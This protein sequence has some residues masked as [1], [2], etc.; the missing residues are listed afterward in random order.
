MNAMKPEE[1]MEIEVVNLREEFV[2]ELARLDA[3]SF[4]DPWSER[5]YRELLTHSYSHYLVALMAEKPIGFAGM[6]VSFDE[7]DIDRV[8]VAP[9]LRRKGVADLLMEALFRLGDEI[10]VREYTLE[11]RRSNITAIALYRKH[12]FREEGIRPGFYSKPTEDALIM[13]KRKQEG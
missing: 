2:S 8:M 11:V 9:K 7:G 13:W 1:S 10:G 12:G 5:A 3:E 6:T 4:T